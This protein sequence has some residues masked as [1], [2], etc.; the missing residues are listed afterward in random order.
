MS[1]DKAFMD[2]A[3]EATIRIGLLILLA[4]WCFAIVK[5]FVIPIVWGVIIA[6]GSYPLFLSL[7]RKLGGRNGPSAIL[8]TLLGLVVLIVPT[9]MLSGT[10]VDS[11]QGLAE[12]FKEG[13]IAVP[14]PSEKVRDWPMVGEQV[15]AYWTQAS[16]NLGSILSKFAP[17]LEAV[18]RWLLSTAAGAGFAILQ[19]VI[20]IIIA[21]FLLANAQAAGTTAH[22]VARRLADEKGAEFAKLAESTVRS[23]TRG[24]LGVALIQSMLIGL[25]FLV[26][27]VPGAGLW[28][29]L[30]LILSVIQIGPFPVV[31]PVLI[32]VFSTADTVPAVIFLVWSLF[33]GAIDNILKPLLLGRGVEVPM[34][35][36]FI[37]AIGGFITS[38]IIGLFVGAVVLVLGYKLFLAWMGE[39]PETPVASSQASRE[40]ETA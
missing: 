19:F 28:A 25:G 20:A 15:H 29:L 10:L 5:P 35:V 30:C 9:L 6:V 3:L 2:N 12:G 13:A 8:V 36:I 26:M 24:I 37:G 4:A 22:A 7:R 21:G 34:A 40:R 27:G 33:A 11:V 31:L 1:G 39:A 32:Y 17:Q 38:G 16:T 23:V 18:G 14:P